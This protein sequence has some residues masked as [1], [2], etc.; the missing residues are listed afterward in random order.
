M[1]G[2]RGGASG[3]ARAGLSWPRIGCGSARFGGPHSHLPGRRH[4]EHCVGT[5]S[6]VL[7][8]RRVLGGGLPL[9]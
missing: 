6:S 8:L 9:Q 7:L 5:R 1:P 4:R 2:L 3:H